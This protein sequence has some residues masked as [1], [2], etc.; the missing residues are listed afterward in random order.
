MLTALANSLILSFG[1]RRLLYSALAGAVGAL[2]LPPFF[3]LPALFVAMPV[4]V[5]LLDG[6]E[7]GTSWRQRVF[8]PA[9]WVGWAFGFG[10][11]VVA[12]HWLGWAF[13]IEAETFAW[14]APLAIV[15]LPAVLAIFFGLGTSLAKLMWSDGGHRVLALAGALSITELARG[16]ILSGFPW[17]MP[18]YALS[19]TEPLMQMASIFGVYGMGLFALVVAAT[20]ALIWPGEGRTLV[21]RLAPLGAAIFGLG[22]AAG[23]GYW[24]I[25]TTDIAMRPDI[26]LRL[27]DPALPQAEKWRPGNREQVFAQL[28]DLSRSPPGVGFAPLDQVTQLI[29]PEAALPFFVAEQSDALSRISRLLPPATTL[30]TGTVRR[31]PEAGNAADRQ[32]APVTNSIVAINDVGEIVAGYDKRR[33]VPFGEYLPFASALGAVGLAPLAA[34]LNTFAPGDAVQAPFSAGNA[35]PLLPLICYE[36]IFAG[37]LGPQ[38]ETAQWLLNL[39]NDA[40]FAG[41]IGPAQHFEQVRLRAVEEGLPLVRVAN[42]GTT[43][44]I[45]PLGRV[46]RSLNGSAPAV[47][48]GPLPFPVKVTIA[49]RYLLLPFFIML[50]VT[51][52]IVLI[53]NRTQRP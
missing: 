21:N 41:S 11:L 33:L 49:R 52:G 30:I 27:V 7:P 16:H 40:W 31:K 5:W 34:S 44:I 6:I 25:E 35:P 39:T 22:L 46:V 28:I 3:V 24:R 26:R 36:A 2:S 32:N 50:F 15:G 17:A 4:L 53:R 10:W 47:L 18:G 13:F 19:A 51:L 14:A 38:T 8:G 20:P 29:W 48:D 9:F 37:G 45:D 23:W 43:A 12:L 1:W 42:R